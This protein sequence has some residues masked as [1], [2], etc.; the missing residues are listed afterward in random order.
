MMWLVLICASFFE[1]AF[2]VCMKLSNGL[3]N[4]KYT[5]LTVLSTCTS[6]GLLSIATKTL[7]LGISYA[8]WTGLGTLF[9]VL[10]GIFVF[11]ESRSTKKLVF[12]GMVLMGV[13]GL[14]L[15]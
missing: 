11:K 4:V 3:K 6:I 2:T 1:L 14:R 8:V 5:I 9:N 13:I 7:P 10:F 12:M 15:A